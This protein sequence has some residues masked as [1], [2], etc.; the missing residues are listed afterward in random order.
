MCNCRR[1][2]LT[3]GIDT[4]DYALSYKHLEPENAQEHYTEKLILLDAL[5]VIIS[6]PKIPDYIKSRKELNLPEDKRL[7]ACPVLGYRI[8]PDMDK[9]F[10]EIMK[11]EKDSEI[12]LFDSPHENNW[13]SLLIE[14]FKISIGEEL[15]QRIRF[16]PYA[17][18][19]DFSSLLLNF[20]VIID[21]LHFSTGSTLYT[22]F[23]FGIPVV[24]FAGEFLRGRSA[25]GLY[26]HMGISGAISYSKK[27]YVDL[28]IRLGNDKDFYNKLSSEIKE[29]NSILFDN[30]QIVD[31]IKNFLISI[32]N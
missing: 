6:K 14:R 18:K 16:I 30:T 4:I 22:I 13:K 8:H 11:I 17:N 27:E 24:T 28:A 3:T 20:D 1:H 7:Y 31:D 21:P 32:S 26:K 29:N 12:I 19:E 15:T 10:A 5:P 23:S 9:I 25:T 2:P